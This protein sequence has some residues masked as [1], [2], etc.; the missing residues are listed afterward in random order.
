MPILTET[1]FSFQ[2]IKMLSDSCNSIP[3]IFLITDGAVEDERHIY[4][5]MKTQ[6]TNQ[7]NVSARIYSLGIGVYVM[8]HN[9][10][11]HQR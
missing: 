9:A 3:I 10:S 11:N 4:D 1:P 8:I 2:A 5:T 7:K 6:L